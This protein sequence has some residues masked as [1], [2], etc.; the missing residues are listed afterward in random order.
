MPG[1]VLRPCSICGRF[2]A[3]YLVHEQGKDW[4]YCYDCWKAKFAAPPPDESGRKAPGSSNPTGKNGH[5]P[6]APASNQNGT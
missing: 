6:E 1:K 2:H 4:Y 3:S 5:P